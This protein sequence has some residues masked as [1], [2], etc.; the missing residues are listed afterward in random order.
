MIYTSA[1][2]HLGDI[3]WFCHVA[4]RLKGTHQ[5]YVPVEYHWQVAEMLEGTQVELLDIKDAPPD[6][7]STWI[8]CG[9]FESQGVTYANQTDMVAYLMRWNN[10]LLREAGEDFQFTKREEMLFNFGAIRRNLCA[11]QFDILVI[12][13]P[14]LSGQCHEWDQGQMDDLIHTLGN[15]GTVLCTNPCRYAPSISASICGIGNLSLRA[16]KIVAVASGAHWMIHSPWSQ[17][18]EKTLFLDPIRLDYGGGNIRHAKNV[19]EAREWLLA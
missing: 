19:A 18:I 5:Y 12:N 8:A 3:A 4:R 6:A 14:P 1:N 10:A 11:P 13:S 2:S 9:R 7:L 17:H 15:T 16:K